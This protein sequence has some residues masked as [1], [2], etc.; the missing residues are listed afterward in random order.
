MSPLDDAQTDDDALGVGDAAPTASPARFIL[1]PR[2]KRLIE[3]ARKLAWRMFAAPGIQPRDLVGLG[4]ALY[5]LDRLPVVTDG[6]AVEF[7]VKTPYEKNKYME[8][9]RY[10]TVR[11]SESEVALSSGGYVDVGHGADSVYPLSV[12][13]QLCEEGI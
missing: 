13:G 1:G 5:A 9:L 10:W 8:I 3:A 2:G 12:G 4:R 7:S 11:I 6:V